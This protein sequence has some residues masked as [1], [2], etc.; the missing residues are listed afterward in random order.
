VLLSVGLRSLRP[1]EP[2]TARGGGGGPAPAE[3]KLAVA[4]VDGSGATIETAE[5]ARPATRGERIVAGT[6]V[7]V[8]GAGHLLLALD[9][10]T[11]LRV[12]AS[13]R[14]RLTA[15]G[16]IQRFDIESGTLEADVARWR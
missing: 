14:V 16:A 12:G 7:R 10:G 2:A 13:S 11:R 1:T 3:T 5:G 9:T 4:D 8:P 6:S 15:L